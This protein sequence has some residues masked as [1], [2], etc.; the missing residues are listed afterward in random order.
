MEKHD[1][2]GEGEIKSNL[3]HNGSESRKQNTQIGTNWRTK[4]TVTRANITQG[5][6]RKNETLVDSPAAK[7]NL[8]KTRRLDNTNLRGGEERERRS[9]KHQV[10]NKLNKRKPTRGGLSTRGR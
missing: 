5:V 8:K 1:G 10:H 6:S 9:R 3:L 7:M 4:L 2:G